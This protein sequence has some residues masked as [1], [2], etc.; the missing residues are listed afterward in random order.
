MQRASFMN[1]LS[2]LEEISQVH[3][4]TRHIDGWLT[5]LEGVALYHA[6]TYGPGE[7][8]IVEVGSFKGKS[9]IWLASGSKR[10]GRE[11]V[12]AVD[13]HL[14]SPEHQKGGEFAS[15]MPAEG[16]TEFVFRENIK[17]TGL[18]DRIVPLV[19]TSSA[20]EASWRSPIRLLFIDAAHSY[21]S[22]RSDFLNWQKHV[23]VN[24][25]VAFHDVDKWDG[26]T[27]L[28]GPS[29][30]VYEDVARSGS[31]SEPIL[32]DHLAFVAKVK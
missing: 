18:V 8:E 32:V 25:L 10:A 22:V 29:R 12:H 16:T 11:L 17:K 4:L 7:G 24:G 19:M 31:Y 2:E 3:R 30:V 1:T 23:V 14:G 27:V 26:S 9:T 21:E 5:E 28:D 13:M 15:H 20:A 6:A